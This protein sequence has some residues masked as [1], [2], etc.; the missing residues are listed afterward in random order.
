MNSVAPSGSKYKN[1]MSKC[2][3]CLSFFSPAF[4]LSS[5]KRSH[6]LQDSLTPGPGRVQVVMHTL[7]SHLCST[8]LRD[9]RNILQ[10]SILSLLS[11][12]VIFCLPVSSRVYRCMLPSCSI[13]EAYTGTKTVDDSAIASRCEL[14]CDGVFQATFLG[15]AEDGKATA[16]VCS[17]DSSDD[18]S[19]ARWMHAMHSG[20]GAF[21]AN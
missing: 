16:T 14:M 4:S 8:Q 18:D 11:F 6:S 13:L 10:L 1:A 21:V 3:Q 5:T 17:G 7:L 15:F 9:L 2:L 20:S 12:F 19:E